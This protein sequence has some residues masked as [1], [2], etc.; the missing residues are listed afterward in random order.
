M[1]IGAKRIHGEVRSM[2]E[3]RLDGETV[4]RMGFCIPPTD[5]NE[6]IRKTGDKN[7]SNKSKIL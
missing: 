1:K 2:G 4:L 7:D 6:M 3:V 5:E